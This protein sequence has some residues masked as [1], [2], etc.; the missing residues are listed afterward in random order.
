MDGLHS[1][2]A[3]HLYMKQ[4]RFLRKL[5]QI[6]L[7]EHQTLERSLCF[8]GVYCLPNLPSNFSVYYCSPLFLVFLVGRQESKPPQTRSEQLEHMRQAWF[9]LAE[10]V[11]KKFE[12]CYVDPTLCRIEDISLTELIKDLLESDDRPPLVLQSE[13]G[14]GKTSAGV[15]LI[16]ELSEKYFPIFVSMGS[17]GN[18]FEP[19]AIDKYIVKHMLPPDCDIKQLFTY[20]VVIVLDSFDEGTANV[21]GD[22]GTDLLKLNPLLL[23]KSW[24][25][26]TSRTE[27]FIRRELTPKDLLRNANSY[28]L[29]P[30]SAEQKDEFGEK[31]ISHNEDVDQKNVENLKQRGVWD[32]LS[33][34]QLLY[35]AIKAHHEGVCVILY[36]WFLLINARRLQL[37]SKSTN[38]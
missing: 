6:F 11:F 30:F 14:G 3:D 16:R 15:K 4:T 28:Y 22:S 9:I 34:P 1:I 27:N 23:S 37:K 36:W 12:C 20:T 26:L 7:E 35:M 13:A 38:R 18:A 29:R 19:H 21:V 32:E 17:V 31:M 25:I 24:V 33:S 8:V 2:I 10:F 5:Q